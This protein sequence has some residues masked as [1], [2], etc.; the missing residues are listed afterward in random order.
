MAPAGPDFLVVGQVSRVH[1]TRGELLVLPLTDHPD[2]TFVP[3][4]RLR[5]AARSSGGRSGERPDE[6]LPPLIVE[7]VR[8]FKDGFLVFFEGIGSRTEAQLLGG[9]YLLKPTQELE[10][11][12][13]DEIFYH[14]LL[15]CRVLLVDG[16]EVGPVQEVY[17]VE[18]RDLLE[19]RRGTGTVLIP[20]TREIVVSVDREAREIR[21]DPPEGLLDL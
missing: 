8:P 14:E 16:S 11:L 2:V 19:V 4:A 7:Q 3:G 6:G 10:P 18:P 12:A 1:G 5:V 21:I 13:E 20:F 15:G 9:R 17:S